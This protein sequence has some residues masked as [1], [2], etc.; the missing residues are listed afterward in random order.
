M[1]TPRSTPRSN[2]GPTSDGY[3]DERTTSRPKGLPCTN[4]SESPCD[5]VPSEWLGWAEAILSGALLPTE[6]PAEW[7]Q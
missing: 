6:V 1:A 5:S 3:R 7:L 4:R 2:I